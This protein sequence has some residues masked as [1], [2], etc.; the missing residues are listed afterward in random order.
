[1]FDNASSNIIKNKAPNIRYSQNSVNSTQNSDLDYN[2]YCFSQ[3]Y[4]NKEKGFW[5]GV[6]RNKNIDFDLRLN[7]EWNRRIELEDDLS[8][9]ETQSQMSS[10]ETDL[11][12]FVSEQDIGWD[13][14]LFQ[15]FKKKQIGTKKQKNKEWLLSNGIKRAGVEL[16][17][18]N[19]KQ[20]EENERYKR[21]KK[22]KE[23]AYRN[24]Q[25][26]IL[27]NR[28]QL[29]GDI[30]QY[31]SGG[32]Y[33]IAQKSYQK[34]YAGSDTKKTGSSTYNINERIGTYKYGMQQKRIDT[35]I[36][37]ERD[38]RITDSRIS[39]NQNQKYNIYQKSPKEIIS[40]KK[41]SYGTVSD[42]KGYG[43]KR[44][45]IVFGQKDT[46]KGGELYI[47]AFA[48]EG[49]AKN[50]GRL[51]VSAERKRKEKIE[52]QPESRKHE[53]VISSKKKRKVSLDK[54]GKP[55]TN[56]S[57]VN[58][59]TSKKKAP[60]ERIENTA[61]LEVSAERKKK[62]RIER[63]P[64]S[65]KHERVISSKKKRKVSL[66]KYG[67]PLTN[68]SRVNID[69]SKKKAPKERLENR[70]RLE[71]SAE[72]KGK[73]RIGRQV[74]PR[75]HS[76]IHS[77][78][79]RKLSVDSEGRPLPNT[80]RLNVDTSKKKA[81][82]ERLENRSRLEVSAEKKKERIGRQ[83]EPRKHSRIHSSKKRKLSVDSEGR[84]L[85]NTS[86]K[87]IDTSK[88]KAPKERLE[89]R[90]RLEVS[91]E[92]KK[93]ITGRQVEPR[94]H[95]SVSSSKKKKLNV[96]NEGKPISNVNRLRVGIEKGELKY[97]Q[98][99]DF[100]KYEDKSH[101]RHQGFAN[102]SN[103]YAYKKPILQYTTMKTPI[104]KEDSQQGLYQH[105]RQF[106]LPQQ[107]S[108]KKSSEAGKAFFTNKYQRI[109]KEDTIKK[110]YGTNKTQQTQRKLGDINYTLSTSKLNTNDTNISRKGKRFEKGFEIPKVEL[111]RE[112]SYNK[113]LTTKKNLYGVKE[114]DKKSE[115]VK[116]KGVSET[117]KLDFSKYYK[118]YK[119]EKKPQKQP[120]YQRPIDKIDGKD[121]YEYVPSSQSNKYTKSTKQSDDKKDQKEISKD[122]GRYSG[123]FNKLNNKYPA[124][125]VSEETKSSEN[126][127][128]RSSAP[129]NRYSFSPNTMAYFKLQF[130]TTKQ[131]VEKFW[132]SI[133]NGELSV[134]MFDPQRNSS[135]LSNYLSPDKNR[136]SKI[137]TSIENTDVSSKYRYSGKVNEK[138][139][140]NNTEFS[141]G[142]T[143]RK[144]KA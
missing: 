9:S 30:K 65:R 82:K 129:Y 39:T 76:R 74:E 53:R 55:L 144:I 139:N 133:D 59:D 13:K 120:L 97:A 14:N 42:K 92:K 122:I 51:E 137:S 19:Y 78:K 109:K 44:Q 142:N 31:E 20:F 27:E 128:N 35:D 5:R 141:S 80:S 104:K 100:D 117:K 66:D 4:E 46:R 3:G 12:S 37:D 89:N 91:A 111:N 124:I 24:K 90:S 60:K 123:I 23:S 26:L 81:P 52:R 131:V 40:N 110:D 11:I 58:I 84:P 70:S 132:R 112:Y 71:V 64:E 6:L 134:S 88:K 125:E 113:D 108:D 21:M 138:I 95:T 16:R 127:R 22:E 10:L 57:R 61:R 67:K 72:R 63:K 143:R 116:T 93:E 105:Q 18:Q 29:P 8:L 99:E 62:E 135:K 43:T 7:K 32:G 15:N 86:R 73:E 136:F 103:N 115:T 94:K 106:T 121:I 68:T 2:L 56:T 69:T 17:T 33:N 1:M 34:S 126:K 54:Y 36:S 77:S 102:V 79:K 49:K 41:I 47:E 114:K 85:P 101:I 45:E 140:F 118:S 119:T 28:Y 25:D 48:L 50:L 83:V 98:L 130:L 96:D 107:F 38:Y 87:N 75:K